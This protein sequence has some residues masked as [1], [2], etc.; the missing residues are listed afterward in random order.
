MKSRYVIFLLGLFVMVACNKED[1]LFGIMPE[2]DLIA[3]EE[4]GEAYENALLYNDSL[5]LCS[6][7]HMGCDST[8]MFHYDELFHQFE[9]MFDIHHD[10][11]SH[12]NVGDDH[13]HEG[14]HNIRHGGMMNHNGDSGHNDDDGHDEEY[15]HNME[16]LELM[17]DLREIHKGIHPG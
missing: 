15:E 10:A 5:Q 2:S 9:E 8:T 1:D 14:G 12:N 11:Y 3:L 16:T 7:E 13:H 17:M 6:T 4:M